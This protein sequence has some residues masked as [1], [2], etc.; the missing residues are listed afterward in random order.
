MDINTIGNWTQHSFLAQD[1]STNDYKTSLSV[2][3]TPYNAFCFNDGYH[4]SHHLNP[5]RHWQDHPEHFVASVEKF[6]EQ[7]TMVFRGYY[8]WELWC[9]LMTK[10]YTWIGQMY[11]DLSWEMNLEQKI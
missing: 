4:T 3:D 11:Q 8:F 2:V 10:N 9:G 5:V 1:G 7:K 6:R